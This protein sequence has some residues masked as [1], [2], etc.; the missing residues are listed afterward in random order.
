M[1]PAQIRKLADR[2]EKAGKELQEA[3]NDIPGEAY[4]HCGHI[5][6]ADAGKSIGHA[7]IAAYVLRENASKFGRV[8]K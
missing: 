3:I 2:I 4:S 1:T 7:L 8:K 5:P 6:I